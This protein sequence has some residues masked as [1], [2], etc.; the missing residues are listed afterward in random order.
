MRH[1]FTGRK[2]VRVETTANGWIANEDWALA[3]LE[4][5]EWE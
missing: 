5:H 1:F 3:E 4:R 2:G